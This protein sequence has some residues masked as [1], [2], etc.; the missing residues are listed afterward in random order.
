MTVDFIPTFAKYILDN[1]TLLWDAIQS[2][3]SGSHDL[4]QKMR[5]MKISDA[6]PWEHF[7]KNIFS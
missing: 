7:D 3:S 1:H 2:Q 5:R 4:N 6:F